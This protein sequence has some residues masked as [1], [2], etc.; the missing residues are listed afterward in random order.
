MFTNVAGA[1]LRSLQGAVRTMWDLHEVEQSVASAS[2][3]DFALG[4]H[5][6]AFLV[7]RPSDVLPG[8]H[9]NMI[10]C[11]QFYCQPQFH[12]AN[13]VPVEMGL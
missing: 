5:L 1:I 2:Q 7:T 12:L 11:Q 13:S 3:M 8:K 10:P 6:S 4:H 9:D